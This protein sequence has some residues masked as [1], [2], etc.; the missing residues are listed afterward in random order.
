MHGDNK[1]LDD[2]ERESRETGRLFTGFVFYPVVLEDFGRYCHGF[3]CL[4]YFL[5]FDFGSTL[6]LSYVWLN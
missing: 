4:F 6:I 3:S 2:E 1:Q 5:Y